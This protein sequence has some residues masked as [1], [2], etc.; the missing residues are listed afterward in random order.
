[1]FA[2]SCVPWKPVCV[3]NDVHGYP[4]VFLFP[5]GSAKGRRLDHFDIHPFMVL[6]LL[7]IEVEDLAV[8]GDPIPSAPESSNSLRIGNTNV[9]QEDAENHFFLPR[10]KKEIYNDAH[11]SFDFAIRNAIFID[12]QTT[13]TNETSDVFAEWIEQLHAAVHPTWKLKRLLTEIKENMADVV[14]SEARLIEIVDRYPPTSKSWSR[15]CTRGDKYAG[16]TC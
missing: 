10:T 9:K 8:V 4:A 5:D 3:E 11:L 7:G 1:M 2:V 6:S 16:Y 13:L 15:S 14:Q 12:K